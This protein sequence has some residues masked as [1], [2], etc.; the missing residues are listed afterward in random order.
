MGSTLFTLPILNTFF[1][2]I[3]FCP[4]TA[5]G[6]VINQYFDKD[7]DKLNPQKKIL[8][9][10]SGKLS[11]R[12]ALFFCVT[13]TSLS[14]IVTA[15]VD[16]S[17]FPFLL[18]Y[19][20]LG[21]A[22]SANPLNLK[23]RPIIDLIIAGIC[24]GILPFLIGMQV[25]YPLTMDFS[26][27]WIM[28]RYIDAFLCSIPL[29]LFQVSGHIYQAIGD[30]EADKNDG[31]T[32]FVVKYGKEKSAKI[33]V[34]LLLFASIIPLFYGSFDLLIIKE[35]TYWYLLIFLIFLPAIIYFLNLFRNPVKKNID[36]ISRISNKYTPF[37]LLM[38]Y[39]CIIILR[40]IIK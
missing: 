11:S 22:Y 12:N 29:L 40:T 6:F 24:F 8:P 4:I 28:R 15:L 33:G 37:L 36:T 16:T 20:G 27:F 1:I 32:T 10:A 21:F 3:S 35:F 39:F 38:T 31:T 34:S 30:Y 18:L 14:F 26:D 19:F 25:V 5:S 17:I 2:S 7:T 23:K 9:V 13:L